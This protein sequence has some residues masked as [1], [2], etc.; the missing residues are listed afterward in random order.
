[1]KYPICFVKSR[2]NWYYQ[3]I[4]LSSH[5]RY[6]GYLEEDKLNKVYIEYGA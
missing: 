4:A 6:R 2:Y 3:D 1:M 5:L